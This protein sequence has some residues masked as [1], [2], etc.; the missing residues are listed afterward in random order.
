VLLSARFA[1][2]KLFQPS[3][4]CG[5]EM[6]E[7]PVRMKYAFALAMENILLTQK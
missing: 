5:D 2:A 4:F 6:A 3:P 1:T 7:Q